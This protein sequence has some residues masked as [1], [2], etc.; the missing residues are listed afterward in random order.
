M[1]EQ[2][3][4]YASRKEGGW[5]GLGGGWAGGSIKNEQKREKNESRQAGL[6]KTLEQTSV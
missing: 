2:M 1:S 4:I 6:T 3:V 5:V